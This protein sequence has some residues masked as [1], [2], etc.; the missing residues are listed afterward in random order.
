M[1]RESYRVIDPADPATASPP[2]VHLGAPV[3][4]Q[5]KGC[6]ANEDVLSTWMRPFLIAALL[7]PA[8]LPAFA[9]GKVAYGSHIGM[10]VTVDHVSGLNSDHARIDVERTAADARASCIGY[11]Q[12]TSEKCIRDTLSDAHVGNEFHGSCTTG[13]FVSLSG[14][15]FHFVGENRRRRDDDVLW[16]KYIILNDK[17][18]PLNAEVASG[19]LTMLDQFEALCPNRAFGHQ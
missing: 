3:S 16:T 2:L 8:A 18:D 5:G 7:L 1:G 14:D 4:R 19:Y 10:E 12:D 11:V 9:A 15:A 13:H 6:A 17:G